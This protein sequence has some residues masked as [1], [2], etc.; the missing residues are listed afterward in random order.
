MS[1]FPKGYFSLTSDA[2]NFY[3]IETKGEIKEEQ[4]P[5]LPTCF[6]STRPVLFSSFYSYLFLSKVHPS[7]STLYVQGL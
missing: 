3:L 2:L 5:V 4:S 6:I 1:S 7:I